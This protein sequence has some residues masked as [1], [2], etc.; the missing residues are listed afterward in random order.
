MVQANFSRVSEF[1][2]KAVENREVPG[3]VIGVTTNEKI[4]YKKAIGMAHYDKKIPMK[5]NTIFDLASLTKVVST[6]PSILRLLDEGLLDL[7]DPITYYLS[8]MEKNHSDITI[9]HLLTHTSGFQ[10]GIDFHVQNIHKDDV[11]EKISQIPKK[12]KVGEMVIYSDLNYILLGA[13]IEQLVKQ[14]IDD[15][16]KN[17]FYGPLGMKNTFFNP[18]LQYKNRIA[19]TEFMDTIQDYQW[20]KVHDENTLHFGGVSSHAGLFSTMEDLASYARMILNH[21]RHKNKQILSSESIK[22]TTQTQT[23]HLNLNRGLGWELYCP[24]SFSGQFLQDGFGHT[25]FTGTSIWL[26]KKHNYAVILLTNRVHF[27]RDNNIARFRRI[28]HN[29][30]AISMDYY[31]QSAEE[32]KCLR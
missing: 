12:K 2:S 1:L 18:P 8:S 14:S 31:N 15:Y 28:V 25:G 16:T 5:E 9:K 27:G 3:V 7:D 23:S 17:A 26:S 19:A 29:L 30:I 24:P 20:G 4:V 22:L 10:P 11:I 32:T 21:G 13:I 6:L